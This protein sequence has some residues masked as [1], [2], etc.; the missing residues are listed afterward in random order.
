MIN[1]FLLI[2]ISFPLIAGDASTVYGKI[3][4]VD[5]KLYALSYQYYV[6]FLNEGKL[7]AY[8]VDTNSKEMAEKIKALVDQDA[9]I[10]GSVKEIKFQSDGQ[11]NTIL[12]FTPTKLS[13]LELSAL[14][15][16]NDT[17]DFSKIPPPL[18]NQTSL[19]HLKGNPNGKGITI[20]D[21]LANGL[22][23]AGGAAILGTL[24]LKK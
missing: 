20:N 24:L 1:F 4:K 9:L 22:I 2:F 12:V 21:N 15:V 6:T 3:R 5:H 23:M 19:R 8:P 18:N 13:R 16:E 11:S 7:L 14:R 17:K 10:E